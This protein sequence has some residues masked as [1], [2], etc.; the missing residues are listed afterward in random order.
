SALGRGRLMV[1]RLAHARRPALLAQRFFVFVADKGVFQPIRNGGTALGHVDGA[2]V[3]VFF[4]RYPRLVLAMVVG[5]IPADQTQRLFASA[6]MRM[7]PV[8]AIGRSGDEANRLV[9][10]PINLIAL[11]VLPR[12]H[13][14]RPRPSVG[15]ALAFDADQH[16]RGQVRVGLRRTAA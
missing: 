9:I 16:R 12:R 1:E 13:P 4:A 8:A 7:E 15:V 6:E 2:L 10:L 3:S 11:A 5:T 14:V